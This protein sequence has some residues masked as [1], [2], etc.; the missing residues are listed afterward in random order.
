V[1]FKI[2]QTPNLLR[3][4]CDIWNSEQ[5]NRCFKLYLKILQY[6]HYDPMR[7]ERNCLTDSDTL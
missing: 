3:V 1:T 7:T 5:Q 2:T 4:V 6:L